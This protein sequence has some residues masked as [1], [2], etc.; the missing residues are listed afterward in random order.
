MNSG[1][2]IYT[3]EV[4]LFMYYDECEFVYQSDILPCSRK[5][6]ATNLVLFRRS[7]GTEKSS[8]VGV[9]HINDVKMLSV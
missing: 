3:P 9:Q 4:P 5:W 1:F 8:G 6:A 7:V 2:F